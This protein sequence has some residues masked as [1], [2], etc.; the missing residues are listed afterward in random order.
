MAWN[1]LNSG[2]IWGV[3]LFTFMSIYVDRNIWKLFKYVCSEQNEDI[4]M[5]KLSGSLVCTENLEA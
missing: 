4:P 1:K 2:K 5:H 3:F